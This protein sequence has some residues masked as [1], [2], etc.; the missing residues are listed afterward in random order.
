MSNYSLTDQAIEDINEICDYL[1]GFNLESANQFLNN[2][3][4]KC[5]VLAQ[6][7]NMGR[8]Y[9]EILPE[10]RGI[11]VNPYIIF[12]RLIKDDVEIIR[13]VNGY[14]NLESLFS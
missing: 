10:L 3:E 14:R 2:I 11:S 12:Y 1:S 6:F 5:Q 8:S 9:A 4:Q 7:P 13:V